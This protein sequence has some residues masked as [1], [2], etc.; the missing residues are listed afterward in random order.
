MA[1]GITIAYINEV[2]DRIEDR[3]QVARTSREALKRAR[4]ESA[5]VDITF[6]MPRSLQRELEARAEKLNVSR[7]SLVVAF[8]ADFMNNGGFAE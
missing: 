2:I 7:S 1:Q 6:R 5:P 4:E 8:M 3:R